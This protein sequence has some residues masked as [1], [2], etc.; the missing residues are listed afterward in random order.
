MLSWFHLTVETDTAVV[1]DLRATADTG[2]NA[3]D[4]LAGIAS[5]VGVTLPRQTRELFDLADLLSP[6]LWFI[7]LGRFNSAAQARVLYLTS[8]GSNPIAEDMLRLIDLWQS[9]T[10]RRVKDLSVVDR[11]GLAANAARAA[12]PAG[13]SGRPAAGAAAAPR[14]VQPTRLPAGPTLSTIPLTP[15]QPAP[16]N[17]SGAKAR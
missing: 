13:D 3:A 16:T 8:G 11:I 17:G 9:A 6:I 1:Q 15:A 5:R 2:G 14:P 12:A 7:E 4:R 10:G